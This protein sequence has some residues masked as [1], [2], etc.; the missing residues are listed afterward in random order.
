M[1]RSKFSAY[2]PSKSG[3][4]G[5]LK[6]QIM[7]FPFRLSWAATCHKLQGANIKEKNLIC[8]GGKN[9]PSL[10]YVM[11][12]RVTSIHRL[13]L[14]D[15][16]DIKK[17]TCNRQA[18]RENNSLNERSITK[19]VK[20]MT[21]NIFFVNIQ[22]LKNNLND[23]EN[24]IYAKKSDFICLAETWLN[25]NDNV[26]ME[27]RNFFHSSKGRG[28]GCCLFS[29]VEAECSRIGQFST[30]DFSILSVK[31]YHSIQLYIIY[32][33][34]TNNKVKEELWEKIKYLRVNNLEL[35]II[36]D[37]NVDANSSNVVTQNFLNYNL[38]QL[39][40]E[41]THIEG[42]TIDHLWVSKSLSKLDLS[43]QYPY[44]SQHKS[45]MIKF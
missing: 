41:P 16:V 26:E 5:Y 10:T 7:Q 14:D 13:F 27:G 36:G 39:V 38:I 37:F 43:I 6:Y 19:A 45:L 18:L 23:L 25:E 4:K 12:S 42:R 2:K 40:N 20:D 3:D 35:V 32:L 34:Q 21:L 17:I 1:F 29:K 30:E 15:K 11:I 22:S 24:D 33:S 31:I 28:K 44:Y 9:I 8:H